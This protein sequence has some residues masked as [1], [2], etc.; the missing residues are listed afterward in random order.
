MPRPE[1]VAACGCNKP[2]PVFAS[3]ASQRRMIGIKAAFIKH[4]LMVLVANSIAAIPAH[5]LQND[6][7]FNLAVFK[8]GHDNL[9]TKA[10]LTPE[11]LHLPVTIALYK[12][13]W[14]YVIKCTSNSIQ[15]FCVYGIL[16]SGFNLV[17]FYKTFPCSI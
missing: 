16:S 12:I 3:Q 11:I 15:I 8:R 6:I 2:D 13:S 14:G 5:R 9:P 1:Y 7:T 17:I 10:G 4:F